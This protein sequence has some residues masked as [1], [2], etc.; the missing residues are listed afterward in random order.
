MNK[1]DYY[2]EV[3]NDIECWMDKDGDPF[4]LSQFKDREEAADYL[5][6]ELWAEDS[7]TGNGGNYYNTEICC[8][9]YLAYN[10]NLI[11]EVCEEFG[12]DIKGLLQHYHDG[13]LARHLDCAIRCYV[14]D[15]AIESALITWEGYGFKYKNI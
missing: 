13:D 12:I 1:Y 5:C 15:N 7:I 10:L 2:V 4:D 8:E 14:L 3:A 6:N 9:G 11:M